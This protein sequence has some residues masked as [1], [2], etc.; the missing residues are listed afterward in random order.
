[1]EIELLLGVGVKKCT[2]WIDERTEPRET[3]NSGHEIITYGERAAKKAGA[4]L[5]VAILVMRAIL[6]EDA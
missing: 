3:K 6:V 5:L 2:C 1:M 4:A